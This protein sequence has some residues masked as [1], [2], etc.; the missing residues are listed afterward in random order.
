[1]KSKNKIRIYTIVIGG[2]LL[3]IN[4]CKK[5]DNSPLIVTTDYASDITLTSFKCGGNVISDGGSEV[6]QRGIS[7]GSKYTGLKDSITKDGT[8]TGHFISNSIGLTPNMDYTI[9][10]YA[11]NKTDTAFGDFRYIRTN[12]DFNAPIIFNTN[13]VYDSVSDIEGNIYKTIKIGTKVWMAENLKVTKYNDG[14]DMPPVIELQ[15]TDPT[16]SWYNNRPSDYKANYGALYNR[17]VIEN[18]KNVCPAGWHV[19]TDADWQELTNSFGGYKLMETGYTH[20]VYPNKYATNESGFTALPGGMLT[21]GGF[22]DC[23]NN[24]YWWCPHRIGSSFYC[25]RYRDISNYFYLNPPD[26]YSNC[27]KYPNSRWVS[28]RCVQDS[29]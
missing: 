4:N 5:S 15:I 6:I 9:R 16:Y 11:I 28:V 29:L 19:S 8:G 26:C 24:G 1:M 27:P 17:Y 12:Q 14:T 3:F 22:I 7:W 20:W 25:D 23:S 13:K 2:L 18:T 21:L 10:A